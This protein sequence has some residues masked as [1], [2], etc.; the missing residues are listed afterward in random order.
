MPKFMKKN[1][2][3][4]AAAGDTNNNTVNG[5]SNNN[6]IPAEI[7]PEIS[8]DV[9]DVMGRGASASSRRQRG[10]HQGTWKGLE[11]FPS[12]YLERI[13]GFPMPSLYKHNSSNNSNDDNSNSNSNSSN[14]NEAVVM[15]RDRYDGVVNNESYIHNTTTPSSNNFN[16][17]VI[18]NSNMASRPPSLNSYKR[19]WRGIRVVA[20]DDPKVDE[21]LRKEV[22]ARKLQRGEIFV[23]NSGNSN[24]NN[25]NNVHLQR[26]L[27][28]LSHSSNSNSSIN[29][30][31]NNNGGRT[32][33]GTGQDE[34]IVI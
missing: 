29:N 25:N 11:G 13:G 20:G 2:T 27:S 33:S 23:G 12:R 26:R 19:V 28:G 15:I 8:K 34:S 7:T 16:V 22:F 4:A 17:N 1:K 18:C 32:K 9:V 30:N 21:R 14:S 31:N 5:T 3:D 10:Q 24:N 6:G